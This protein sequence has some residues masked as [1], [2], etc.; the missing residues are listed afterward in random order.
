M[1]QNYRLQ[2]PPGLHEG[3]IGE[4]PGQNSRSRYKY[5]CQS[6]VYQQRHQKRNAGFWL[7]PRCRDEPIRAMNTFWINVPL[8]S[9]TEHGSQDRLVP[10][11]WTMDTCCIACWPGYRRDMD[12]ACHQSCHAICRQ[13]VL[14]NVPVNGGPRYSPQDGDLGSWV[15]ASFQSF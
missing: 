2:Q 12:L 10:R 6:S 1:P 11:N 8:L 9:C 7:A 4:V 13:D 3:G 15:Y 5:R 14:L